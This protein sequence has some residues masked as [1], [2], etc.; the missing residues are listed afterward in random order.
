MK[1]AFKCPGCAKVIR[2]GKDL[3]GRKVK[4]PGCSKAF[5]VKKI[6]VIQTPSAPA[7]TNQVD[8]KA[9]RVPSPT[10]A[11]RASSK[12]GQTL[13][14]SKRGS[15]SLGAVARVKSISAK[16]SVPPYILGVAVLLLIL[17][18][19][20]GFWVLTDYPQEEEG[21]LVS[22]QVK[23]EIDTSEKEKEV[24]K[25]MTTS[26]SSIKE[27]S[28]N[29][30]SPRA[31]VKEVS[32][33][34]TP[35][36][37]TIK[38]VN[39]S[40]APLKA[41]AKG[42]SEV[43]K[44]LLEFGLDFTIDVDQIQPGI[45]SEYH[46]QRK[47]LMVTPGA[48]AVVIKGE[49]E[50]QGPYQVWITHFSTGE[51]A[52]LEVD[53]NGQ[54][55]KKS[56]LD[57]GIDKINTIFGKNN[58]PV[59]SYRNKRMRKTQDK[60]EA[61]YFREYLGTYHLDGPFVLTLKYN[62]PKNVHIQK[63]ELQYE[64]RLNET[65]EELLRSAISFYTMGF[66][67]TSLPSCNYD[68][69]KNRH[70]RMSSC[71]S[72]GVTLM[73]LC[74][75]Y[76]LDRDSTTRDKALALLRFYNH[77]HKKIKPD[78]HHSGFFRHFVSTKTGKGKSEFSTIDTAILTSGALMA[79]NTFSEDQRIKDEADELWSSVAWDKAVVSTD[80]SMPRFYLTGEQIDGKAEGS[81][82][83]YNE[84]I[85]LA[86]F[87]QKY[88]DMRFGSKARKNIMPNLYQLPFSVIRGRIL[89]SHY[90][91]P[92]FLVQFPFYMSELCSDDLFFSFTAAQG[93]ADRQVCME[94][95][96][97][98]SAWGVSPGTTPEEGYKVDKFTHNKPNV[99]RPRMVAGFIPVMPHAAEDLY[100][101][102]QNPAH[103]WELK[104]G[105]ILPGFIPGNDEWRAWRLPG[106]DFSS[107]LFG[108][109]A[110]HPKIGI[111]FFREKTRFTFEYRPIK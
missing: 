70:G 4:C 13:P 67:G 57:M 83:M 61:Y 75:Q 110:H 26:S 27:L 63:V 34:P 6:K 11:R 111:R 52:E 32:E 95:Y 12:R 77:K 65:M 1:I 106:I 51:E 25:I 19:G 41:P 47:D 96:G 107:L 35:S 33:S 88:E 94:R 45:G 68:A 21:G 76:E 98:R 30:A 105:T 99:V 71:A 81:I 109:A 10:K 82:T 2:S 18:G 86:Y 92:S 53:F 91:Q 58:K 22:E 62:S 14:S 80:P 23:A 60:V 24:S 93:V 43:A 7:K 97:A 78:R 5:T 73:A 37:P 103:R 50:Y 85:L 49:V 87:C 55:K 31:P 36:R 44:T 20:G 46:K 79:R 9:S 101:L 38:E 102:Y 89:L 48:D 100:L 42:A 39:E 40:L 54:I 74:I 16:K 90:I 104:I 84:Y 3:R 17:V 69:N 108:M 8:S 59:H 56:L 15:P 29:L 28:E 64:N 72:S 66:D